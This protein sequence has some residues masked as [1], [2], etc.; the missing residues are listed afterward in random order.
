MNA[1]FLLLGLLTLRAAPVATEQVSAP[2]GQVSSAAGDARLS[3]L[4]PSLREQG[5]V[6]LAEPDEDTRADLVESL[7]EQDAIGALDFLP[8]P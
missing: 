2:A 1:V 3:R 8:G 7:A 4:P 5:R 6:I